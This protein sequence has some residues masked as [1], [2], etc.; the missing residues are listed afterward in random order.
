MVQ[1]ERRVRQA[2]LVLITSLLGV[3]VPVDVAVGDPPVIDRLF[4]PG[5]Q[6]GTS[7]NV[8]LAGKPGEEPLQCWSARGQLQISVAEDRK[9]AT[10]TIPPDAQ[11]GIHWLR[12][13]NSSGTSALRPF[14]VGH[15][16][17]MVEEESNDVLAQADQISHPAATINGVLSQAGDVDICRI[18]VPAGRTVVASMLASRQLNSPM[19]AVLQ[20]LDEHGTVVAQNDDDHGIDPQI[21]WEAP[22]GGSFYVRAFAFPAKPNST[23][24]LAGAANYVYRLTVTHGPFIDHVFPAVVDR[25]SSSAVTIC[26]WNLAE[27]QHTVGMAAFDEPHTY[28]GRNFALPQR[29]PGVTHTSQLE[30]DVSRA[31]AVNSSVSGRIAVP[32]ETDVYTVPGVKGQRLT[33]SVK[34]RAFDSLLDPLLIITTADGK[35][36]S[37]TD[38]TTAVYDCESTITVPADG[39]LT[40]S[41]EDRFRNGGFRYFYTLTCEVPQ[42]EF[43]A[44]VAASQYMADTDEAI[45]IPV[46]ITRRHGF[47]ERLTVSLERL[48]DGVTAEPVTSE[49]DGD[50]SKAVTLKLFRSENAPKF[51]GAV[52]VLC[53][54]ESDG[55]RQ[56]A[57]AAID[58]SQDTISDIWLTVIPLTG[59]S[60]VPDQPVPSSD[61]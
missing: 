58:N 37:E 6:L 60:R 4:P 17:E 44:T 40:V 61:N 14:I 2:C 48:P 34:A 42:P 59:G 10:V 31:L 3:T 39:P 28:F 55:T 19:D 8:Q 35:V 54:D 29:V 57:T 24:K 9:F 51:S 53:R 23:I 36:L 20:L 38:D 46:T 22:A 47:A 1:T 15:I 27:H 41:V 49:K 45:D 18:E 30:S 32:Q 43:T 13:F 33:L 50:S 7:V 5:G 12:F 21:A 11:P 56:F 16:P 25:R 52:Q 26:G